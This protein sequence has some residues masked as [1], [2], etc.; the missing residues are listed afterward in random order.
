MTAAVVAGLLAG[1]GIAIPVGAVGAYLVAV[2]AR[3]GWRTGAGAALGVATADGVYAL[4][5]VLGG[6]ALVPLLTP[7]MTP[8]RWAS[9][10]VLVALAL[11]A[12]HG[13]LA[14]FRTGGLASRDDGTAL[15]PARAYLTFLGI[16][17]LNPMTVIYF[18]ALVLAA[19]PS[20]PA[21]LP[22]RSAFVLAA[23]LASASWQLLLALGG[24]LLGRT[25]AGARGRLVTAL[26]SSTLI[27][28]LAVR[29]VAR[30]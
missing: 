17:V 16:T 1:Y 22:D 13:A 18:A 6:S 30:S 5:A 20:S 10:V 7:V 19:G 11:R 12:A 21:T 27:V 25:L 28:V 24:T 8:L 15:T 29:L 4:V 9:A 2:T 3:T 23:V 14:A 26:A